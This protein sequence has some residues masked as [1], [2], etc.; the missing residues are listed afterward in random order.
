MNDIIFIKGQGGLG[1]P[2]AGEDYISGLLLYADNAD[3]PSGWD[4]SNRVKAIYSVV[5]AES[6]GILS[7]SSDGTGATF[8]YLITALGATGDGL[9]LV[10][11][12]I[13]GAQTI[14]SYKVASTETTID[15]QG[16]AIT[17]L[18][19]STTYQT[20]VSASY[21]SGTNTITITLPK[22]E[23]L[24]PNSGT[25]VVKTETGT[26]AGTL[27]QPSGGAP[28]KQAVWHYQ[29]KEFFR[30]APKG[31]LYVGFYEI[32]A[33]YDYTEVTLMQ[34]FADGTLRQ[35]GVYV[36]DKAFDDGDLQV[37][38][39]EIVANCDANHK[40][41]S[42]IYAGDL[43]AVSDLSTLVNLNTYTANK[44]SCVISQDGAGLGNQLYL[45][46]GKSVPTLGA[47]L[48]S[49]SFAAVSD[50][51]AWVGKF[52]ISNGYECDT[53]AISN[54]E[55]IKNIPVNSLNAINNKRYVFLKK[56]VGLAGSYFN[57]SHTSIIQSSDYAYI[58]NNRTI[59]K[60]IRGVYSSVL[61][62]LNSPLQLNSDGTLTDTTVAYFTSLAEVNLFEM[63][64]NSE[65]SAQQVTIDPTQNVLSTNTLA[66]SIQIVPIG[67]ARQIEVTIG[68]TTNIS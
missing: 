65:I 62:A 53:P 67:V 57:D 33:T 51:I 16:D 4:T 28:S 56:F 15:L 61:P 20:N 37:L 29:I 17:A 40:P 42:A 8:T 43:S 13:S 23:G 6:K 27:A 9:K 66:I 34:D 5:D 47:C 10:Y 55:L 32:P 25:P 18:I 59:D 63:L 22:S 44:V 52:N 26:F 54:G 30:L 50:D 41:L 35:V 24:F 19:N 3:L 12:G 36:D 45:A 38:N 2:L 68:F 7:D 46:N 64:R 48:G 58:E 31:V 39:D 11:T 60:A 14:I 21:N 1:R 49:V